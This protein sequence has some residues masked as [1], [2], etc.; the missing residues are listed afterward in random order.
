MAG[1]SF[2]ILPSIKISP[3][4]ILTLPVDILVPAALENAITRENA[5]QIK[6]KI[7]LEM[8][9]GPTTMEADEILERKGVMVIPDILANSGGVAVSYFEWYQN[10]HNERWEREDVFEKLREKMEKA[11]E[12][13]FKTAQEYKV[14]LRQ[15]A[16]IVALK[17]LS[18]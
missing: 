17:R 11:S 9:N 14:S 6:A 7:V 16:Y 1:T 10:I 13:V 12:D 18:S 3:E 5:D 4:E 15:A 2:T 8:A